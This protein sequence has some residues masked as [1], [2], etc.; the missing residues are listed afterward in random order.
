M[1]TIPRKFIPSDFIAVQYV[2]EHGKIQEASYSPSIK[3]AIDKLMA[4]NR[5]KPVP[6]KI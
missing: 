1:A 2:D 5:Y 3:W 6:V 4:K